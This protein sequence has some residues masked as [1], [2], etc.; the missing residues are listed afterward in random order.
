MIVRE[1]SF[2]NFRNLENNT[3]FPSDGIN[4]I[5]GDNAQGKT[6]MLECLWLFTGNRSF[7]GAKE[8]ELIKFDKAFS[9]IHLKFEAREREQEISLMIKGSNRFIEL[10]G[11]SKRY[12]SE[13]IGSFCCVVF[14]PN[15]LSLIKNGPD[16]RR[17][18]IDA[19]LCQIKPSYSSILSDYKTILS[20]RNALLK[21]IKEH[22]E[23]MD[24]LDIWDEKL[25]AQGALVAKNRI[26]YIKSFSE[27]CSEF[28]SGISKGSEKIEIFYK[29]SYCDDLTEDISRLK[30]ML[31]ERLIK[32]QQSDIYQGYTGCGPHRDDLV[33]MI[34][35]KNARSFGSQGQ[36]RSAVLAMK[37]AEA[38]VLKAESGEQP[39]ILL[40]D[41]LS[42]LDGKRQ[43]YLLNELSDKQVFI[44]CCESEIMTKLKEGKKALFYINSGGVMPAETE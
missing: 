35:G 4:V 1:L 30:A 42:E 2:E 43:D 19:A 21:D 3:I 15:H 28:Y 29:L 22:S 10:N 6:N 11:V 33:V 32:T 44:T 12:I 23:L 16:E 13:I 8:N 5:Y 9:K 40:D 18:F 36:Q 31:S 26:A 14:S 27:Y 25:A 20:S 7:R 37:L 39:V 41:V 34:D 24:M 17:R 38:A